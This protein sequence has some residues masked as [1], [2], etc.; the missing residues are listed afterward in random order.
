MV[1]SRSNKV[2]IKRVLNYCVFLIGFIPLIG[3]ENQFVNGYFIDY[4][5]NSEIIQQRIGH[6]ITLQC[7]LKGLVDETKAADITYNWYFKQCGEGS[8]GALNCYDTNNNEDWAQLPCEGNVC[9]SVLQL[10][11]VTTKYSGLYKCTVLPKLGNILD[12]KLVRT[13]QLDIK[14]SSLRIPEF[15]D[16]Y[17]LNKTISRGSQAVFQCRVFSEEY[18]T[19]KW[20]RR[21]HNFNY[22]DYN[23]NKHSIVNYNG[24]AYELLTTARVKPTARDVYLSKL[25]INDVRLRDGGF[26]ACV[27]LSLRGHNIREAYLK[28]L[29]S[30]DDDDV[31]AD[32]EDYWSDYSV[33][34]N[35]MP[36]DPKSFWLLF[37]MPVGLALLPLSVWLCYFIHKRYTNKKDNLMDQG[38]YSEEYDQERMLRS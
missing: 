31:D 1:S 10:K 4:T 29:N 17:P 16:A 30:D 33:E 23:E 3:I 36:T 2:T 14:N 21:L 6:N 18:P 28:V 38:K 20:F 34:D 27:A 5:E 11:N 32:L 15:L 37:L 22:N 7:S 24:Q 9:K 26:Y 25:I 13:F 19:I 35:V 8:G 12:V